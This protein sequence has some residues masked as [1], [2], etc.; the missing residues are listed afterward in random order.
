MLKRVANTGSHWNV[1]CDAN[2]DPYIGLWRPEL[3]LKLCRNEVPLIVR[4]TQEEW[5]LGKRWI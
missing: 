4:R 5:K 3:K 1:A 2:M